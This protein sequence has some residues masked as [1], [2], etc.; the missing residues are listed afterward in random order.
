MQQQSSVPGWLMIGKQVH[1]FL[2]FHGK[3]QR[4]TSRATSGG[5]MPGLLYCKD[6][7]VNNSWPV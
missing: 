1:P 7:E 3:K 6:N 5:N 2:P 4:A